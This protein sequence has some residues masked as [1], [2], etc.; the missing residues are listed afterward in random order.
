MTAPVLRQHLP[1]DEYKMEFVLPSEFQ[2]VDQVPKPNDSRIVPHQV[3]EQELAV[4]TFSGSWDNT[5]LVLSKEKELREAAKN[6]MVELDPDP[7][8]V[9]SILGLNLYLDMKAFKKS[10]QIRAGY[11]PPWTPTFLRTNELMIPVLRL[12]ETLKIEADK[13]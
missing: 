6:D 13:S 10:L 9:V 3:P 2:S 7:T 5:E 4:I 8:H 11:N 1:D 12:P